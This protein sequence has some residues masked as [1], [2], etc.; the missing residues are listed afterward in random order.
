MSGN[1]DAFLAASRLL[2][3]DLPYETFDMHYENNLHYYSR[4]ILIAKDGLL[5]RARFFVL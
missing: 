5:L 1:F 3:I 4:S 2:L